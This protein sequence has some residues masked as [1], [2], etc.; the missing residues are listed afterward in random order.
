M[1]DGLEEKKNERESFYERDEDGKEG[2]GERRGIK[3]FQI[4]RSRDKKTQLYVCLSVCLF[5][6]LSVCRL[7]VFVLN[8]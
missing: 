7:S 6:C 1:R 5:V 8:Q 4:T 3:E 2:E